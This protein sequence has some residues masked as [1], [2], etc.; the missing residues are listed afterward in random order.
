MTDKHFK[1]S[2]SELVRNV[3]ATCLRYGISEPD[4]FLAEVM[5]GRDPRQDVSDLYALVNQISRDRVP[6]EDEWNS[7]CDIVLLNP[8]YKPARVDV[9]TS[10]TAAQKLV[11]HMYPK[12]KALEVSTETVNVGPVTPLT[13]EEIIA[14]QESLEN[15]DC[16]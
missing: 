6:T 3:K 14:Y 2:H 9:K 1:A 12:L 10:I 7:I 16:F 13:A 4:Q 8:E 5:S 15:D 11:D